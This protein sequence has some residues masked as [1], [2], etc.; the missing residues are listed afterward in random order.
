[1]SAFLIAAGAV[2]AF[3]AA[4]AIFIAGIAFGPSGRE[5]ARRWQT[6]REAADWKASLPRRY[7]RRLFARAGALMR[8]A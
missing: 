7:R 3:Y 4:A 5:R 1:M 2:V 8:G 6:S